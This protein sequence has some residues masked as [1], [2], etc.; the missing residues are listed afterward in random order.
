[1]TSSLHSTELFSM[2]L[3]V[4]VM[5]PYE[6]LESDLDPAFVH[7]PTP[8]ISSTISGE[9]TGGDS[10]YGGARFR[11]VGSVMMDVGEGDHDREAVPKGQS[12]SILLL[13]VREQEALVRKFNG[14]L[15]DICQA[16]IAV[17]DSHN[18]SDPD[19]DGECNKV[20]C[21]KINEAYLLSI[22]TP[23]QSID[24][25]AQCLILVDSI[26]LT[27]NTEKREDTKK[28][29]DEVVNFMVFS[30]DFHRSMYQLMRSLIDNGKCDGA[31]AEA[32]SVLVLD[33]EM[34]IRLRLLDAYNTL[35]KLNSKSPSKP[36]SARDTVEATLLVEATGALC[37]Q[38]STRAEA[39]C[40]LQRS[41]ARQSI[42]SIRKRSNTSTT[43]T[44]TAD[45]MS[46][47]LFRYLHAVAISDGNKSAN[48]VTLLSREE[49]M[50][51]EIDVSLSYGLKWLVCLLSGTR[52]PLFKD[53]H[54]LTAY[55]KGISSSSFRFVNS[56]TI[57]ESVCR[58]AIQFLVAPLLGV[59]GEGDVFIVQ[60][61]SVAL[62]ACNVDSPR[63]L[64][65][66][67]PCVVLHFESTLEHAV[68]SSILL[69]DVSSS[70]IQR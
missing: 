65:T 55:K 23:L 54:S 9:I 59:L 66:L 2:K 53:T 47:A 4:N 70:P 10:V 61:F 21:A 3:A 28:Q 69:R 31:D 63:A 37:R 35:L 14:A 44:S 1:M 49:K 11:G 34:T 7:A 6:R 51:T 46:F 19:L 22:A 15:K 13:T 26:E 48:S 62:Q 39:M 38:N 41:T 42:H 30:V 18:S 56:L 64:C 58:T 17:A 43:T 32:P 45:S 27:G 16:H 33:Y 20:R 5:D 60:D 40:W 36:E 12:S 8:T 57:P 50:R 29:Y 24:T 67:L 25:L 52:D 68:A